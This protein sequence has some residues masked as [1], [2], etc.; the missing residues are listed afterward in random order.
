MRAEEML[1]LTNTIWILSENISCTMERMR[2]LTKEM[3]NVT[4]QIGHT[5]DEM[6]VI[7]EEMRTMENY[8]HE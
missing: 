7:M 5:T 4:R 2:N 1:P 6:T 8:I 3:E